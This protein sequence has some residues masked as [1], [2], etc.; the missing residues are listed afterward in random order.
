[1][2]LWEKTYSQT[3]AL[4]SQYG[5]PLYVYEKGQIITQVKLFDSN[6]GVVVGKGVKNYFA[7][8]ALPNPHILS[9][10]YQ[11][12]MGFDC[13]SLPEV[14][15]AHKAGA[16]GE[17]IIYTSNN[18]TI[19]E[20][21]EA[22]ADGAMINFDDLSLVQK[23]IDCN[24]QPLP[25]AFCRYNPGDIEFVGLNQSI[26][27]KPSE[28][29]YGMPKDQIMKA[30]KLLKD[31]G[32]RR[33]GLHTML[34]SNELDYKNHLRIARLLFELAI[35][36]ADKLNI[37]FEKINLGGGFGLAYSPD[38]HDFDIR[39]YGKELSKLYKQLDM[40][41]A[42]SPQIITENG[43]WVT[44]DSGY[45]ITKVI[46]QKNTH[47]K[48][49]GVDATMANLMRPGMYGAYH[50]ISLLSG[51][52]DFDL[53]KVETVDV[54]GSLCEN[55]DKFAVQRELPVTKEGDI[56]IIHS[57]GAHGHAMGFQYNGK[58]RSAEVLLSDSSSELIRRAE[59]E[60]D[61]FATL[62]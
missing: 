25:I 15:L 8:K 47:R 13:S 46:N 21:T 52:T 62:V 39:T 5:S 17:D 61:Y 24:H 9:I 36:I 35:E 14:H 54:V 26:I 29:K 16:S 60:V 53:N 41:R 48:Y 28:A 6:L 56:I 30:Y 19:E 42:G 57:A 59:T 20:L 18:T 58:L 44:G 50:H 38:Q 32:V 11:A 10:L 51:R 40:Q 22:S 31:S 1:M 27:G 49:I 43:R 7:V 2:R 45:L 34:L 23:F 4:L 12:G 33:F 55:N 3:E 37:K